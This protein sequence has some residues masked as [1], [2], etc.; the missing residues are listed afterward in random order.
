MLSPA[1]LDEYCQVMKRN[2]VVCFEQD[3]IKIVVQPNFNVGLD[4]S[5]SMEKPRE[6]SDEEL[7]FAATEGLPD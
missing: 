5:R 2:G 3:G 6:Y 4:G 1:E 7:M